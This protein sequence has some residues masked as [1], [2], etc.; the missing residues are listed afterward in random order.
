MHPICEIYFNNE[1]TLF[2]SDSSAI[3]IDTL[4][5]LITALD[6]RFQMIYAVQEKQAKIISDLQREL[7]IMRG[8]YEKNKNKAGI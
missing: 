8:E 2:G 5:Q 1:R 3:D 7:K 6:E 4:N